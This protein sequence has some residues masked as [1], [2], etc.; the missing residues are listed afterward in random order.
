MKISDVLIKA[1]TLIQ[2]PKNWTQGV[3]ARDNLYEPVPTTSRNAV[4]FCTYGA[5]G[6][7]LVLENSSQHDEVAGPLKKAC[8][9]IS[10]SSRVAE[11]ND[12]HTHPEVLALFDKAIELAKESETC[13]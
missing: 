7:V 11:Y 13:L 6:R 4:C 12:T 8:A 9:A 1:K 2:D 3:L 10:G 5:V